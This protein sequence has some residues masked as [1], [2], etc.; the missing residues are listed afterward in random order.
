VSKSKSKGTAFETSLIPE[1]SY[2]Y[3]G[4]E[5][6][7]LQGANDKG[8]FNMPGAP[9]IVE[10]K[11]VQSMSLGAWVE[12]ANREAA[13]AGLDFGVVVHKR[14]GVTDPAKQFCTIEL[15]KLLALVNRPRISSP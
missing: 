1:L 2:W 15:G 3:P 6:R 4:T 13:N 9:F 5:R 14:R 8:D 12:E 7:A 10:A 11:N